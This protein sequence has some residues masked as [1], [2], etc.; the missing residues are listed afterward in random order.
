[1]LCCPKVVPITGQVPR[2][3]GLR[4][5]ALFRLGPEPPVL[6]ALFREHGYHTAAF[7]SSMVLDRIAGL[8]RGFDRYD[9]TVRVGPR[10]AFN[11]EER[12]A[13]QTNAAVLAHLGSLEPP[14]FLWVHYFD[15]H[16]PYVPPEPFRERFADRLYDGE[17][18]FMD[19][20]LGELLQAVRKKGGPLLVAVA[21]DHGESL[22]DHG[23]SAHGIFVYQS[24][25]H[26][27]L[28]LAGPGVPRKTVVKRTVGLVDVAPT[29]LE[30][31]RPSA[32]GRFGR[33]APC[34]R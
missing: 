15:P 8:D 12:A 17:I 13:V 2:R 9:D 7:V 16:L 19:A 29:L 24:T 25:Q 33:A 34:C 6:A 22:G 5:N 10:E 28:I 18:A 14:F 1:M 11:H 20:Q 27:P 3:H 31:A 4:N 21:G 26:V 30:L 32:D 23:E